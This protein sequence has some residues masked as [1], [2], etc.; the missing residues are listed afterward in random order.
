MLYPFD[1]CARK[2]LEEKCLYEEYNLTIEID[3]S[4]NLQSG[5]AETT[6]ALPMNKA[7]DLVVTFRLKS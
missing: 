7:H 4:I 1:E 6:A 5:I 2:A 3:Y